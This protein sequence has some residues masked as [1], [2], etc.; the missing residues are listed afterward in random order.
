[1]MTCKLPPIIG[2]CLLLCV[3]WD[4][5]HAVSVGFNPGSGSATVLFET[6]SGDELV[7]G[8]MFAGT[9]ATPPSGAL[10]LADV[11]NGFTVFDQLDQASNSA[12]FFSPSE[13]SNPLGSFANARLYLVVVDT[14]T[15]AGASMFTVFRNDS[16]SWTFPSSDLGTSTISLSATLDQFFAGTPDTITDPGGASGT[17]PS[18]QLERIRPALTAPDV[19]AVIVSG[20]PGIEFEYPSDRALSV[21][22]T[23]QA[24]DTLQ[25]DSFADVAATPVV[26]G[27][28]G[29]TRLIRILH[30]SPAST[31]PTCFLRLRV[32][33]D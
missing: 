26:L 32:T 30:P 22:F 31:R 33:A 27:D 13:F 19:R 8:T 23:L 7:G 9:F 28:N 16:P 2:V 20:H 17:F 29:T 5:L 25:P 14:A 21:T 12:G 6:P 24:S 4:T 3:S 15:I 10:S 18:I 11:M 1:M